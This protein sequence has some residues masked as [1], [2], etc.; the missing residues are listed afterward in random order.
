MDRLDFG[1]E[2]KLLG[3]EQA[4]QITGYASVFGILDDGGDIVMPG[5]FKATLSDWRKRKALPAMLWQHDR[6]NPIGVWTEMSE[7]DKG[8][9]VS[10]E[11]VLG[12]PQ[13]DTAY[14]LMKRGAVK[15]LSIGYRT[16]DTDIDRQTGA[17]H[18]KKADLY[19]ISPV[20]IPMLREARIESVKGALGIEEIQTLERDL[21]AKGLSR[22]DANTSVAVLKKYLALR[23]AEHDRGLRD[24]G[25]DGLGLRD[26]GDV[27]MAIRKATEALRA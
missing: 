4:G 20:T 22:K 23:D 27:L 9:K 7:D 12:I 19:E 1:C 3:D 21:I 6:T 26:A 2:F 10:G 24:A 15:G 18:I 16:R 14:A 17:R 5:A 25:Q 13:A 11:L 8:L